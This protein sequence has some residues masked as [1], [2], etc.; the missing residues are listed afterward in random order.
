MSPKEGLP[1]LSCD[2]SLVSLHDPTNHIVG[3]TCISIASDPIAETAGR[4]RNIQAARVPTREQSHLL[5]EGPDQE[6]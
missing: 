6:N 3:Y 4:F 5:T 1:L 2:F